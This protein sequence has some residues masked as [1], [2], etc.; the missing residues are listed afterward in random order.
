MSR[1]ANY[2]VLCFYRCKSLQ[3]AAGRLQ[4]PPGKSRLVEWREH[5]VPSSR[6]YFW[7]K[8]ALVSLV[9]SAGPDDHEIGTN[10]GV[11]DG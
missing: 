4:R 2:Y 7:V 8:L 11:N 5:L 10:A 3:V 9:L 6:E 1:H